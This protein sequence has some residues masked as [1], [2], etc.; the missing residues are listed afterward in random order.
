M[1][2]EIQDGFLREIEEELR[3]EHY[4]KLWKRYGVHIITAAV[5]LVAVV[6]GYQAWTRYDTNTRNELGERFAKAQTLILENK[7]DEAQAALSAM[8]A[9]SNSGYAMLARFRNA[10]L[11][12]LRGGGAAGYNKLVADPNIDVIYRDLA[13]L[14]AVTHEAGTTDSRK[15][16]ARLEPLKA[17]GNPWRHS[18]RELYAIL[19]VGAGDADK[20]REVLKS[21]SED[22]TAPQGLRTRATELLA[23][24]GQ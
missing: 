12:A 22:A 20:A 13:V 18:A 19:A 2:E 3:Q 11:Q 14:L 1:A 24:T 15:L 16:M 23:A 21:L 5:M 6:G 8:A 9:D 10:A 4:A 7:K 17:D